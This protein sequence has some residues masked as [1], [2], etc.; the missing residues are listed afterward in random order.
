MRINHT[1]IT[2]I[3][4]VMMQEVEEE[5]TRVTRGRDPSTLPIVEG[6]DLDGMVTGMKGVDSKEIGKWPGN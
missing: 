1:K 2:I 4:K 6:K 3:I 5:S